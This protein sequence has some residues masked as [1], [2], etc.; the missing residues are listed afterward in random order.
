MH[1]ESSNPDIEHLVA[2]NGRCSHRVKEG[3]VDRL[4]ESSNARRKEHG[5]F[6][7]ARAFAIEYANLLVDVAEEARRC[8]SHSVKDR[9]DEMD[10][11]LTA[12]EAMGTAKGTG[13]D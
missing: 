9:M 5:E 4:V 1:D 12:I 13:D 6:F 8:H 2:E 3:V 7:A 10:R 11:R